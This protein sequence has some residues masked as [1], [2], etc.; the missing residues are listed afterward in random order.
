MTPDPTLIEQIA[1]VIRNCTDADTNDANYAAHLI[2]TLLGSAA[3]PSDEV[4]PEMIGAGLRERDEGNHGS[5]AELVSA[6]YLA[7]RATTPTAPERP[8]MAHPDDLSNAAAMYDESAE[9]AIASEEQR[10]R[11]APVQ[12]DDAEL[13]EHV[14]PGDPEHLRQTALQWWLR[15]EFG[16]PHSVR[17]SNIAV[18][19]FKDG[20]RASRL[21][22]TPKTGL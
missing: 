6:V 2:A 7:M 22:P 19:A 1:D 17:E 18:E 16:A 10:Q 13:R 21:S 14:M 3:L 11:T 4:T 8:A 9:S 5:D 15:F 20:Y 12:D